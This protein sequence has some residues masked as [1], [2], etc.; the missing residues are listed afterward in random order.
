MTQI[1]NRWTGAVLGEGE[2]TLR[3][4][5]ISSIASGV[6][7]RGVDLSGVDL[8]G[9]IGIATEEE[10]NALLSEIQV[11]VESMPE[12]WRMSE[13]HSDNEWRNKTPADALNNCGTA[14]C[15]AGWAQTLSPDPAI[16]AMDPAR[17]GAI[18]LPRHVHMFNWSNEAV[19]EA[20]GWNVPR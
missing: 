7:L 2:G 8:S 3:E 16:R 5:V 14:H 1:K 9:V 15:L 20:M 18:L 4:L 17:A 6:G 13:W 10:E 11:I 12:R 19:E